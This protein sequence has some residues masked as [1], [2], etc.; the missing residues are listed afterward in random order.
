ML[1]A[2][3]RRPYSGVIPRKL[4]SDQPSF[5]KHSFSPLSHTY[6]F[7][8][9]A[10]VN[11]RLHTKISACVYEKAKTLVVILT[12]IIIISNYD[13][14]LNLF[15]LADKLIVCSVGQTLEIHQQTKLLT[16]KAK[17][18]KNVNFF[19]MH[20]WAFAPGAEKTCLYTAGAE[21]APCRN[22]SGCY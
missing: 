22:C 20:I 14:D 9:S 7:L 5:S 1:P 8:T 19:G 15:S 3:T 10:H 6:V 12:V 11:G 18:N 21:W 16:S 4:N 13:P 17:D 2:K